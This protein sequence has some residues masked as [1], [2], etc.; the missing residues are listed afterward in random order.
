MPVSYLFLFG[1]WMLRAWTSPGTA[2]AGPSHY[3][4]NLQAIW[5]LAWWPQAFSHLGNP[6]F[7][8]LLNFP[9]GVNLEWMGIGAPL[10]GLL[11]WPITALVGVV[12]AYNVILALS[13]TVSAWAIFVAVRPWV[14]HASAAYVA[15]FAFLISPYMIGQSLGH[16]AL[17]IVPLVP[18][19]LV[20]ANWALIRQAGTTRLAGLVLGALLAGQF[21]ISEEIAATLLLMLAIGC[22]WLSLL[23]PRAVRSRLARAAHIV[24]WTAPTTAI[25]LAAPIAWQYLGPGVIRG[26]VMPPA[27]FSGRLLGFLYPSVTQLLSTSASVH[28][29]NVQGYNVVEFGNY[30]GVPLL[31]VILVVAVLR[32]RLPIVRLS[33]VMLFTAA[34]LLLGSRLQ[35]AGEGSRGMPLPW[36]LLSHIPPLGDVLPV[37]LSLYLDLFAVVLLAIALDQTLQTRR[38][39]WGILAAALVLVSWVPAPLTMPVDRYPVP[40]YFAK[41]LQPAGQV[42]LVV[43]FSQ[44]FDETTAMEWQATAQMSFSMVDGYYSR[45]SGLSGIFYHGPPLNPLT[46]DL[47]TL[48]HGG[49]GPG[50][51]VYRPFGFTPIARWLGSRTTA[52]VHARPVVNQALLRFTARF[53]AEHRVDSVVL[54]PS[55][56]HRALEVFLTQV[57]GQPRQV[58]GVSLWSPPPGGW[59]ALGQSHAL[60]RAGGRASLLASR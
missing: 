58:K 23:Y 17:V 32:W 41:P 54:G 56:H 21:F 12:T 27:Q 43:P 52:T 7:T 4:D 22:L 37:R 29:I 8:T 40:Q 46:W 31:V 9:G 48:E 55:A 5:Y 60:E 30:I 14:Q 2:V 11:G 44:S 6:L 34:V 50:P 39:A 45:A 59:I 47:W 3:E 19:T 18:L 26:P 49:Y 13:A 53:L 33:T 16:I 35:L 42:L 20:W 51:S 25:I 10:I 24:L 1:L 38:W 57:F 15:A 36:L 28:L